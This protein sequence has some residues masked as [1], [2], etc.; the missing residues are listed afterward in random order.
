MTP[1]PNYPPNPQLIPPGP[2]LGVW[3]HPDD[4]CYLSAGLM[5]AVSDRG[6]RVMCVTATRGEAG[7]QDEARWPAAELASIREVELRESMT[8]LG[9][10]EHHFLGVADGDC[11]RVDPEPQIDALAELIADLQPSV[12]VTFGV[13]GITDHDDHK[14]A[15]GWATQAFNRA[16]PRGAE[17]WHPVYTHT[18]EASWG[19]ELRAL[20]AYP[21][22]FP[23]LADGDELVWG[24]C[25]SANHLDRKT[26]ALL[27]QESQV[28][29]LVDNLTLPRYRQ[30]LR[31]E[32]F[33]GGACHL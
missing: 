8:I 11:A 10:D 24:A 26:Q 15:G 31:Q 21:P 4:E 12:V 9:V 2:L 13:D 3:A 5:M 20:G 27:A 19:D 6:D 32:C 16:A 30:F 14:A 28:G 22:G 33:R 17:L 23:P 18:W 29:P 7:V 25:L 1:R